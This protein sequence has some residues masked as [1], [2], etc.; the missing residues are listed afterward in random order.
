MKYG[1]LDE[2]NAYTIVNDEDMEENIKSGEPL[3]RKI[4]QAR[5]KSHN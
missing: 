5:G 4:V 1:V 2:N 3:K